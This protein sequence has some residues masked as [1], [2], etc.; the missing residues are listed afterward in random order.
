[1][2]DDYF[3]Q[4][5]FTTCMYALFLLFLSV[6]VFPRHINIYICLA[7]VRFMLLCKCLIQE[8]KLRKIK[9]LCCRLYGCYSA[10]NILNITCS[11]NAFV[12]KAYI[13][14]NSQ[15]KLQIY[16]LSLLNFEY[17][18]FTKYNMLNKGFYFINICQVIPKY[19]SLIYTFYFPNLTRL[20]FIEYNVMM[21]F[22]LNLTRMF[23]NS[24]MDASFFSHTSPSLLPVFA[25]YSY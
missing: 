8:K 20:S 9:L 10:G 5:I 25:Q 17:F 16:V 22:S 15:P 12:S 11:K 2:Y 1:M 18:S 13:A 6:I 24:Y 14:W 3:Y 4:V 23:E 19:N 21:Y 7:T